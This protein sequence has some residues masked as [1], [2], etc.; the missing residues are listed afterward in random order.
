MSPPSYPSASLPPCRARFPSTSKVIVA[1]VGNEEPVFLVLAW[2]R[3]VNRC[4][5]FVKLIRHDIE[6]RSCL[7]GATTYSDWLEWYLEKVLFGTDLAPGTPQVNWEEIGWL[8][9]SS[10]R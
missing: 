9:T 10:A 1:P 2:P 5:L 7:A 6:K 4:R 8:T 3:A